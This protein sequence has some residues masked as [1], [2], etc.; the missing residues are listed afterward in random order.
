MV[1]YDFR[2]PAGW[3]QEVAAFQQETRDGGATVV[4]HGECPHCKH[5]MDVELP[6]KAQAGS[7]T[8]S[9]PKPTLG[10][11]GGAL[12]TLSRKLRPFAKTAHCNCRMKHGGR[13]DNVHEGCGAFGNLKVGG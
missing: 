5:A 1:D 7:L 8:L 10:G 9:A 4:L 11:G 2:E 6:L 13:P 12:P 3:A